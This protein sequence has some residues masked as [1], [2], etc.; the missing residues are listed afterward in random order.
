MTKP[1][2]FSIGNAGSVSIEPG[3]G[4]D[5]TINKHTFRGFECITDQDMT[6]AELLFPEGGVVTPSD[7]GK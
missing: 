5:T 4:Q 1:P 7:L 3:H 2:M 6:A